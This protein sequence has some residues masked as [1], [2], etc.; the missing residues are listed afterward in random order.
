MGY[1]D[2]LVKIRRPDSVNVYPTYPGYNQQ[3]GKR[4]YLDLELSV[5]FANSAVPNYWVRVD[6]P[7]VVDSGGHSHSHTSP[8]RPVGRFIHP[9]ISTDTTDTLLSQT[10]SNGKLRFRYVASQFSGVERIRAKLLSD[11]TISD[12][13]SLITRVPGLQL[14]PE[15]NHYVKVGG[16]CEHHGPRDDALYQNCRT[17]DSDHWG[18]QT[19]I[20]NIQTIADSFAVSYSGFRLRVNDLSLKYGGGFDI[21]GRWLT[22]ITPPGCRPAGFGHCEHRTGDSG[23]VSF[24][25]INPQG[26][27]TGITDPQKRKLLDLITNVSGA[28]KRHTDHYHIR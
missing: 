28:P 21:F 24:I 17:P 19:L 23:D 15:G 7:V 26:K 5:E 16:T 20:Q 18:T 4:N 6:T 8:R 14:L 11:T 12:T 27:N 1:A 9:I 22:D 10:D 13:L 3:P 2:T 25:V